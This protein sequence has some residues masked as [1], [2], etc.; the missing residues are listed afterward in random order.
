MIYGTLQGGSSRGADD[1][2][3]HAAETRAEAIRANFFRL[4]VLFSINHATCTMPLTLASSLLEENVAYIGNGVFFTSALLGA[5]FV[6]A[7]LIA[8]FGSRDALV[9]G[10]MLNSIYMGGFAMALVTDGYF[11][12]LYSICGGLAAATLW[13]AQG[14]CF[15]EVATNL[16]DALDQ[17]RALVTAGVAGTFSFWYL[18]TEVLAKVSFTMLEELSLAPAAVAMMYFIVGALATVLLSTSTKDTKSA[19]SSSKP[20][21]SLGVQSLWTDPRIWLLSPMNLAFGFCAAFMN[22]YVNAV[23]LKPELGQQAVAASSAI[24]PLI[25]AVFAKLFGP[26][27]GIVGKAP[28]ITVGAMCFICIPL[29]LIA[30]GCCTGWGFWM[31]SLYALQGLGRAVYESTN[32]AAFADFFEGELAQL[33][34]ANCA[35]QSNLGFAL[36][37]FLQASL[38]KT[39]LA[40]ILTLLAALSPIG[41]ITATLY[42]RGRGDK[43]EQ[44]I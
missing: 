43:D 19:S 15:A 27:A 39:S 36:S 2:L 29:W 11:W 10:G 12:N 16:A 3:L 5:I 17:P 37:F 28:V 30:F 32:R 33:A 21:T 13:T 23:F 42:S 20:V 22:G 34:F 7:P 41:Y 26:V 18:L 31:L 44:I 14:G 8:R 24:T 9:L 38:S 25:A 40:A 35:L 4:T 6:A 1:R